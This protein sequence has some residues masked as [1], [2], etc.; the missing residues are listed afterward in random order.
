MT[1]K[2]M[3]ALSAKII[4][5]YNVVDYL[6]DRVVEDIVDAKQ[7]TEDLLRC[8]N[9]IIE[10]LA[11]E[12]YPLKKSEVV[13]V[14]DNKIFT[15]NFVFTP[16]KIVTIRDE[17]DRKCC[18]KFVNDYLQVKNGV[19]T[20]TYE[21]KPDM[22]TLFDEYVYDNSILGN[23]A[24]A[25]GVVSEYLAECGVFSQAEKYYQKY[26]NAVSGRL[27]ETRNLKLPQRRWE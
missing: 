2:D 12:Y 26:Q 24:V 25:Y 11:C 20:V 10:E 19:L 6:N 23:F 4:K 9:I 7:V 27:K 5:N 18:F 22:A 3:I 8:Y 1:V 21:Y 13:Y 17:K 15:S 14:S 16:L